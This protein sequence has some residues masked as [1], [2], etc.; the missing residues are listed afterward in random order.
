MTNL[1]K[2]F[3][4]LEKELGRKLTRKEKEIA[5][6]Y[7][8]IGVDI[9]KDIALQYEKYA[10]ENGQLDFT[11]LHK[12][13]RLDKL[14]ESI[15]L[16]VSSGYKVNEKVIRELLRDVTER[17]YKQTLNIAREGT[18][19]KIRGII[20]SFD[21]TKTLNQN[22]AG[23]RWIER[24]N[25][26]KTETMMKIEKTIL[27][28]MS[29]GD[30]Y[31]TVAKKLTKQLN[32]SNRKAVTIARTETHRCINAAK[33]ES[34]QDIKKSGINVKKK[35]VSVGDERVRD[36]HASL[37]GTII[38]VDENFKSPLGGEGPAPGQ[39]NNAEDDVNCRC[40]MTTVIE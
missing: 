35:W 36:G 18:K 8:K 15:A 24:L 40:I 28:G 34:L 13:K 22:V 21:I 6:N 9:K 39:M 20:K 14:K 17:S 33:L 16:S 27:S 3:I 19:K 2:L 29:Q 12:Y 5:R 38:D 4:Q 25:Y 37:D 7:A 11:Q 32:I 30:T 23:Y 1:D 31:S 10:L 26:N